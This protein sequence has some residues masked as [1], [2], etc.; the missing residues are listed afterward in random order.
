MVVAI[1]NAVTNSLNFGT[2]TA[3]LTTLFN[4]KH[5]LRLHFRS[6]MLLIFSKGSFKP[7]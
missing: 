3:A 2:L 1:A 6:W 5:R 4:G 7:Q